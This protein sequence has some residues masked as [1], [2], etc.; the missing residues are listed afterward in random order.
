MCYTICQLGE[1]SDY[2]MCPPKWS[3]GEVYFTKHQYSV[4]SIKWRRDVTIMKWKKI[5]LVDSNTTFTPPLWDGNVLWI[6]VNACDK[7]N[8][9]CHA[10]HFFPSTKLT[11]EW[12]R[13][14]KELLPVSRYPFLMERNSF[15]RI[16]Y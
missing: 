3:K 5:L 8:I 13:I 12:Q 6:C 7:L 1:L 16:H 9:C 14:P 11:V 15:L 2:S 10:R 4:T